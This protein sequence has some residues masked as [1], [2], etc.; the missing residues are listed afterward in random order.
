[1][2]QV[3]LF[4]C[5]FLLT[6]NNYAEAQCDFTPSV[7]PKNLVLCPGTEDTL[8]TTALYDSYQWYKGTKL[9]VGETKPYLVVKAESTPAFFKVEVT[10]NGCTEMSA[11]VL[12][13]GYV[14]LLPYYIIEGNLSFDP[15]KGVH[16]GCDKTPVEL[17]Y[18]YPANVQWYNG[19]NPIPGANNAVYRPTKNGEYWACGAPEVCPNYIACD[20]AFGP[21]IFFDKVNP[22]IVEKG[23][24]LVASKGSGRQFKYESYRWFYN[25]RPIPGATGT[26]ILPTR[27][28]AY[29]VAVI[30]VYDCRGVSEPYQ[31]T[32]QTPAVQVI[33]TPN[34]ATNGA[35]ISWDATYGFTQISVM[36]AFGKQWYIQQLSKQQHICNFNVQYWPTGHYFVVLSDAAGNQVQKQ[37]VVQ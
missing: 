20:R 19:D 30:D 16:I 36:D 14:F 34:P 8:R 31:F 29:R 17:T 18:S 15:V 37:L 6:A 4:L 25:G 32:V 28:G 2:K 7:V 5:F 24:S 9:L 10:R 13:D 3:Y 33:L 35:Q 11:R 26:S 23:D 22:A 1:M 12:V 27:S 21:T